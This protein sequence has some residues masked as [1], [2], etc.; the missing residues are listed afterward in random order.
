[1]IAMLDDFLGQI[2]RMHLHPART[3]PLQQLA[4]A[5]P[6]LQAASSVYLR[7]MRSIVVLQPR[8]LALMRARRLRILRVIARHVRAVRIAAL[9]CIFAFTHAAAL[10]KIIA[11]AKTAHRKIPIGTEQPL[12]VLKLPNRVRFV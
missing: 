6:N 5:R 7:Q 3:Q 11:A 4:F 10:T 12:R 8:K 9:H 2:D 1:M